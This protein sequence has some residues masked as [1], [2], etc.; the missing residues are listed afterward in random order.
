VLERMPV[1][2]KLLPHPQPTRKT[3]WETLFDSGRNS[4]PLRAASQASSVLSREVPGHSVASTLARSLAESERS[5]S[6]PLFGYL[7][8]FLR[9]RVGSK[10]L[11]DSPLQCLSCRR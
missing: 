5:G 9:H 6:L 11:P 1:P 7:K 2:R 4:S 8:R 10:A 3:L